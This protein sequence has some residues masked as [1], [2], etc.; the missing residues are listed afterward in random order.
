MTNHANRFGAATDCRSSHN[1]LREPVPPPVSKRLVSLV[2]L[3]RSIQ[4]LLDRAIEETGRVEMISPSSAPSAAGSLTPPE[5]SGREGIVATVVDHL[6]SAKDADGA[7]SRYRETIR[8]HLGRFAACF[9]VSIDAITASQIESWLRLQKI[10]P[11]TRNNMRA[12]IVTLF[13]FARKQGYLPKS[14]PTEADDLA[15]AKEPRGKI[16]IIAPEQLERVLRRA[17]EKIA[18]FVVLGAFSGLRSSEI[19]RL[20]WSDFNFER[21]FITVAAEKTK[22]ATRRLVPIQ[23]NLLLWL[24][25]YSDSTGRLFNSRRD[26]GAAIQFAK[27]CQVDWPNNA[28][29]HSYATY[30]L[31]LAADAAR[32]ALEMGTSP[33]KLMTNYRELADEHESRGWFSISP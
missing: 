17:P 18:L 27:G 6:L 13:R 31:A 1:L 20:E 23:G 5:K 14:D 22:T 30:R 8:S 4:V 9:Q 33:G 21:R 12:S 19:L 32:V 16:G 11:R 3:L 25:R 28:L 10:G 7:S 15:K 26:A 29:R 24:Q 2:E